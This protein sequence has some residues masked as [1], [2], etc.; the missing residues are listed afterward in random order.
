[1]RDIFV[2]IIFPPIVVFLLFYVCISLASL[3]DELTA[4]ERHYIGHECEVKIKPKE[5]KK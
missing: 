2:E 5:L 1:M 3:L 4:C